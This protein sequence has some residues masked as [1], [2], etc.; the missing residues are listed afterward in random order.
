MLQKKVNPFCPALAHTLPSSNRKAFGGSPQTLQSV[1]DMKKSKQLSFFKP[2][3]RFFGGQLLHGKRRRQ[4]PLSTKEPIHI[5]LRSS[6]AKGPFSFLLVKNKKPIERLIASNAKSYGVKVYRQAI[7]GNH[8]HLII[9]IPSRK[10]YNR[11]IRVL[12]SQVASHVMRSLSFKKFQQLI[13][14]QNAGD[15]PSG[16]EEI[17]GKGQAF[18]QFRP[19]TRVMRWGRDYQTCCRY[20]LQNTLEALGFTSYKPRKNIYA[21][22]L[23]EDP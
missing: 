19:W 20:L 17:Q 16:A 10:A 15:P 14:D 5:V 3:T 13:Y 1:R 11:F 6:W 18:W 23:S 4:R 21:K 8:F 22:W 9:Q 12:S 2:Y 7:V